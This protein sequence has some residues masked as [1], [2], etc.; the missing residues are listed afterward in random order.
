MPKNSQKISLSMTLEKFPYPASV[1]LVLHISDNRAVLGRK[2]RGGCFFPNFSYPFMTSSAPCAGSKD[3]RLGSL[4]HGRVDAPTTSHLSTSFRPKQPVNLSLYAWVDP[5]AMRGNANTHIRHVFVVGS[6]D[7]DWKMAICV[8]L[9]EPKEGWEK[10]NIFRSLFWIEKDFK[11][12]SF[13]V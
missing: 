7:E 6:C 12:K 9:T 1:A 4:K 8:L 13:F 3:S 2:R 10:L 5:K 11:P